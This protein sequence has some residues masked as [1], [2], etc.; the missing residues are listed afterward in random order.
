MIVATLQTPGV[1]KP[2]LSKYGDILKLDFGAL[3]IEADIQT[4]IQMITDLIINAE[5][6]DINIPRYR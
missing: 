1:L 4:F 5:E 6:F 2:T 3:L